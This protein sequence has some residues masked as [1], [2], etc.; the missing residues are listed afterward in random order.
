MAPATRPTPSRTAPPWSSPART[1]GGRASSQTPSAAPGFA[2]ERSSDITGV[3]LAG[4]AKNAAVLAAATAAVAGPNAAGAAA[5]RVFAEVGAYAQ[6]QGGRPETF[7]GLAGAGDLVAT[8]VADGSRNRRAGELLGGG[9][10]VVDIEPALG[11]SAESL[12]VVPLL[13]AALAADGVKA[14]VTAG[15]AAVVEG[16]ADAGEWARGLTGNGGRAR[17]AA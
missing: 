5:G 16:S 6:R 4:T 10:R 11:Q 9:T 15:L 3:E 2:I 7:S 13:A 8:V 1:P 14:P 17:R 12:H